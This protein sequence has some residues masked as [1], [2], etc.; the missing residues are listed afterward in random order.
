AQALS[1]RRLLLGPHLSGDGLP[2]RDVPGAICDSAHG[3][4]GRTVGRD[5]ARSRAE[6]REAAADLHGPDRAR[7]RP[8]EQE[9]MRSRRR[10]IFSAVSVIS[11]LIVVSVISARSARAQTALKFDSNRAW[12]HLRQLVAIGPR[13]S[14]SAAIE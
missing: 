11:A 2:C 10:R 7:L 9:I 14:G 3:R 12:E 6:D 1:Q 13:P 8:P 5:A 4:M